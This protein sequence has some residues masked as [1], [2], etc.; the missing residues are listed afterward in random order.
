MEKL[1][2]YRQ[3][4]QQLLTEYAAIP[5]SN[6]S[7]ESHVIFDIERDHYQVMDIGWD[8]DRRVHGCVIHLDIRNGKIWLQHNMTE[9]RIA[10]ELV[11]MGVPAEDIVLGLHT[12]SMWKY[13]GFGVA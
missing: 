3:C 12:P 4:I 6:G 7:I 5:V 11:A 13:T 9:R 2:Y 1:T 8:G 10:H